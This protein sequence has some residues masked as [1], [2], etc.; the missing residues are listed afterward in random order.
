MTSS[1]TNG[2]PIDKGIPGG[3]HTRQD[4]ATS[5]VRTEP[6]PTNPRC[7]AYDVIPYKLVNQ[8]IQRFLGAHI[9]RQDTR[10]APVRSRVEI[11]RG[12]GRSSLNCFRPF[13]LSVSDYLSNVSVSR[14]RSSNWTGRFPASR[15]R[16]R[17]AALSHAVKTRL[18][19]RLSR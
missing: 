7:L 3:S 11:W 16:T 19:L 12:G 2:R 13:R 9:A 18:H 5:P 17:G 14:S 1:P 6:H 8:L 15:F 10:K 4:H